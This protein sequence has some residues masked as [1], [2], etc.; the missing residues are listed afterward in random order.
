MSITQKQLAAKLSVSRALVSAALNDTPGVAAATRNR[1]RRLAAELGYRP[2]PV[3]LQLKGGRSG[4][5]GII[6]GA[7]N[8]KVNFDRMMHVEQAAFKRGYRSM[9]GQVH[10]DPTQESGGLQEYLSDFRA[11]GVDAV[12]LLLNASRILEAAPLL[13]KNPGRLLFLDTQPTP[14]SYCVCV[15]RA[16]G[17]RRAIRH[18][19][20][21]G[22]R[23][24]GMALYSRAPAI[25]P[26]PSRIRGYH[27]GMRRLGLSLDPQL[28][29]SGDGASATH[30][31]PRD[32]DLALESLVVRRQA[33]A[34]LA[35]NDCWGVALIK[36]LKS[37]NLR[38]P[39]DVAVIG[40]DNLDI[41]TA[42]EPALTTLDQR[43]ETF[44]RLTMELLDDMTAEKPLTPDRRI[45]TVKPVLIVRE[46]A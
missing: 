1:I 46:S 8:P 13:L 26:I 31:S 11:R 15:D 20:H 36:A 5:I 44:A 25:G 24:I 42:C 38:V 41:G 17:I 43:H 10:V 39:E 12:V 45:R 32:I 21:R 30:P 2:N 29:W 28:I 3:A 34:I 22:C 40:F 7:E 16:A 4:L 6:I 37:R 19:A 14:E 23:R 9:I 18:L 35:N 33:D 27:E